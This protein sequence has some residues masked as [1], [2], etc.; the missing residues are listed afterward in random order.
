MED[1]S[2]NMLLELLVQVMK[3]PCFDQLRT[4][5]QLGKLCVSGTHSGLWVALVLVIIWSLEGHHTCYRMINCLGFAVCS[6][7]VNIILRYRRLFQQLLE[8]R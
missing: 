3:E 7:F 2:S 8:V 5:E 4:K 1:V 6:Q